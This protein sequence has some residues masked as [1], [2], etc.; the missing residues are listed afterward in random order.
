MSS[1]SV[2]RS[3]RVS[4]INGFEPVRDMLERAVFVTEID[5]SSSDMGIHCRPDGTRVR[6]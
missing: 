6:I 1:R 5:V 3:V 4:I 2:P